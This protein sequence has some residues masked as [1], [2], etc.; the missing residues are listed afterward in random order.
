ME[1]KGQDCIILQIK[2]YEDITTKYNNNHKNCG[3]R[4]NS[5]KLYCDYTIVFNDNNCVLLEPVEA[6]VIS[7]FV[8]VIRIKIKCNV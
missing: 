5:K 3:T 1:N 4:L 2:S 7:S 8:L 6:T